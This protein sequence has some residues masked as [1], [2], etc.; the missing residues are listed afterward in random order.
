MG[1]RNDFSKSFDYSE[2]SRDF[3]SASELRFCYQ[4]Y[5]ST[6]ILVRNQ[7]YRN[8]KI[9]PPPV[10]SK[11][12]ILDARFADEMPEGLESFISY[13]PKN[14]QWLPADDAAVQTN[15]LE[16][17]KAVERKHAARWHGIIF[18]FLLTALICGPVIAEWFIN[19]RK[20]NRAKLN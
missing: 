19:K 5:S 17:K 9:K 4:Q 11:T 7:D 20:T 14:N 6:I 10:L 16:V 2:K 8:R 1:Q 12:T 18:F 3:M 15:F 13:K